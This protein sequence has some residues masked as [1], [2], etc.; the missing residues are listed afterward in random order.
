MK[1]KGNSNGNKTYEVVTDRFI[2][3]IEEHGRLP[4]RKPWMVVNPDNPQMNYKS[5]APYKGCNVFL[6][7]MGG[8]SSP[9]WLTYK[10][11]FEMGGHV[12]K[13][14][15]GTPIIRWQPAD[16]SKLKAIDE[17][18][19]LTDEEKS[20][21]KRKMFGFYKMFTAFNAEQIEG[22]EF[23]NPEPVKPREFSPIEEAERV[24]KEMP[25]PP[26]IRKHGKTALYIPHSD[27]VIVPDGEYSLSGPHYYSTLFHELSHSTGHENRLGRLKDRRNAAFGSSDYSKEELVAELSSS[28]IMNELGIENEGTMENSAAYL[29]N[30]C[31]AMKAEPKMLI[32]AMHKAIPATNY[33]FG[34][35]A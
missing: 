31:S 9:Y 32:Q 16:K 4:W 19:N 7:L 18:N 22:I 6:T 28:F 17:D 10:Q 12:K 2:K 5:G 20:E 23:P 24:I 11:A 3:Y 13:G 1:K 14:E 30:W 27:T 25:K 8:Y 29:A 34:R 21:R 26:I 15:H 35:E 33:I